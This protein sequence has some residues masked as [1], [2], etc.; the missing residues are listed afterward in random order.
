MPHPDPCSGTAS[1]GLA[2]SAAGWL[3]AQSVALLTLWLFWTLCTIPWPF[4]IIMIV[5]VFV[6][7]WNNFRAVLQ[8][9]SKVL[10][11]HWIKR[12]CCVSE[13]RVG[14]DGRGWGKCWTMSDSA[15]EQK[16]PSLTWCCSQCQLEKCFWHKLIC[17][18]SLGNWQQPYCT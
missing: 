1:L 10:L 12:M 11:Q 18:L 5:C 17:G 3:T 9:N 7:S 6:F 14:A 15:R 4:G 8:P 13:V 16:E 2:P